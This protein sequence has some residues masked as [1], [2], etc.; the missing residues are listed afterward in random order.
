MP[1]LPHVQML[2]RRPYVFSGGVQKGGRKTARRRLVWNIRGE[3]ECKNSGQPED[4]ARI[5]KGLKGLS[6]QT[7]LQTRLLRDDI[8][9]VRAKT[10]LLGDCC[11]R[12]GGKLS[13]IPSV[14]IPYTSSRV[15]CNMVRVIACFLACTKR[16]WIMGACVY[17]SFCFSL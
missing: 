17:I 8:F 7:H 10:L 13:L 16:S 9:I 15:A 14:L 3:E 4:C 11:M 6:R 2:R 12:G 5:D 1:E